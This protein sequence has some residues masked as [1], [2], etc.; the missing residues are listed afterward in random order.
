MTPEMR[1]R[2]R[3]A[4]VRYW[5]TTAGATE[6]EARAAALRIYPDNGEPDYWVPTGI[7][8]DAGQMPS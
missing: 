6:L 5:I 3:A 1:D 4:V 7:E 2:C 8:Y